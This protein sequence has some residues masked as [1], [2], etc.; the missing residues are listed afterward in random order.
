MQNFFDKDGFIQITSSP[1]AREIESSNIEIKGIII[2]GG[3]L[4]ET[5]Y[6]FAIKP[7][8]SILG[9]IIETSRQEPIIS[10]LPDDSIRIFLGFN[11]FTLDEK[12]DLSSNSVDIINFDNVFLECDIAQGMVFSGKRSGRI[13]NFTMDVDPWLQVR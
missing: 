7:I 9:S 13:H 1:G 8:F 6:T 4:T 5:D 11:A 3:H 2:D 10:F 12:Y